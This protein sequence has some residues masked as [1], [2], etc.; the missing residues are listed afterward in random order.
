MN[1]KKKGAGEEVKQTVWGRRKTVVAHIDRKKV[2]E[3]LAEQERQEK[4]R[5]QR[6]DEALAEQERQELMRQQRIDAALAEQERKEHVRQEKINK[7]YEESSRN[8]TE[9]EAMIR[10]FSKIDDMCNEVWESLIILDKRKVLAVLREKWQELSVMKP[11]LRNYSFNKTLGSPMI[12]SRYWYKLDVE[13]KYMA[14]EVINYASE[15]LVNM[16]IL[17][18]NRKGVF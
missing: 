17:K 4:L 11:E 9:A 1:I 12:D 16:G 14:V 5:Q 15:Y 18:F 13:S 8:M 3:V 2:D 10:S 6:I 7:L